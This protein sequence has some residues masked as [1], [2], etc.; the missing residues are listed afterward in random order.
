MNY[1][2][3]KTFMIVA[4]KRSFS[5]A[6]KLLYVT[7]PTITAQIKSL[8]EELNTKLFERTTKKVELTQSAKILMKY[9]REMI[10]LND[11]AHK[12]IMRIEDTVYGELS[13][14]CSF[15]IGEYILPEFL[16][17]FKGMYPL[18]QMEVDIT[19][20]NNI[21]SNIKDQRIDVGLIETPI[22]DPDVIV[23][24]IMEDELILIASSSYLP[25]QDMKVSLEKLKQLPL[26]V[27]EKGSGTRAVVNQYL[28]QAGLTESDLNIVMELGST[29]AIKAVVEAGLGVSII[30][31]SAIKKE[32]ELNV[33]TAHL[34]QN[35]SFYRFFYIAYG[36][37]QVLKS[38]TEIFI[39]E[40]KKMASKAELQIS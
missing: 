7:Q 23:E 39:E 5:E 22:D 31:R 11:M 33:L 18:I 8:E 29:E 3:L 35:I 37:N 10:R 26:I 34:I 38:T 2:K 30:S 32:Q 15:T 14:G 21:V 28:K 6:A 13:M 24:P 16:K 4:E 36:R 12:E 27:R 19:N 9:A 1:E 25:K 40:L 20:S 17:I